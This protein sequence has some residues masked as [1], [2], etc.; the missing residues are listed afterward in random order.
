MSY[1]EHTDHQYAKHI[2]AGAPAA[3][4][5]FVAWDAQVMRGSDKVIPPKYTELMAVAVAL[6]TQCPYCI[7]AHTK[8]AHAAGAT[9][10]E[11]AETVMVAAALRAG[12]S[13]AHGFMAMK[14]FDQAESGDTPDA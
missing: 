14:F 4:K 9:Q 1:H 10:Q 8:S 11:L 7:E 3:F 12:G 6:T 13:Y 5:A 2:R